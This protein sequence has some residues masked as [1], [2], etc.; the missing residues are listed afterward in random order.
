MSPSPPAHPSA[1]GIASKGTDL[2]RRSL[3]ASQIP[4]LGPVGIPS[5]TPGQVQ[6]V[7]YCSKRDGW[8]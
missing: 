5:L 1:I 4:L 6:G 3:L 8:G 7:V 2:T